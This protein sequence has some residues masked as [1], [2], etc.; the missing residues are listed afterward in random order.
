MAKKHAL[1]LIALLL[2]ATVARADD[3]FWDYYTPR[4]SNY[5][6]SK[7][8]WK[9]DAFTGDWWGVRNWLAED[10]G[11]EFS[12]NY[13]SNLAGNPVGGLRQ[14]FTYTDN[15]GFGVA[16]DLEKLAGWHGAKFTVSAL[17]RNGTSLSQEYIGN[18]FTVQQVYGGQR[19]MF[20]AVHLEQKFWDDK[21]QLKVGRFAT[22]DDFASSPVY[23]LYMNNGIDGNPQ[24]LPVNAQFSAY[25]WAVWATR[26]RLDPTP[27]WNAQLG[28][29][30]VSNR[31]FDQAY[32]GLNMSMQSSDGLMVLG[33][34]GWTPEFCKRPVPRAASAESG[35]T[36]IQPSKGRVTFGEEKNPAPS[37]QD[38]RGLPGHYWFGGYYSSW[39]YP[40]F[41]TS[42]TAVG[43]YGFYWHGDQMI[44]QE[45]PGSAQGFTLWTAFVLSPE[46]NTAKMPFQWNGGALYRGLL[47]TRDNDSL[48]FGLA[49]GNFSNDYGDAGLAYDGDAVSYEMALEWGYRVQVSD[50][51]YLQPDVQY[52][53]QPGGT[54][55]IPNALVLGAQIGVSF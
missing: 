13:T 8:W 33:Q 48:L 21:A 36:T 23:W 55:S 32:H 27:E 51:I 2:L 54:G 43:A 11:L 44:Y 20:Y 24:A 9:A 30:Q 12:L 52:I 4:P 7:L 10:T 5:I 15:I 39:E 3:R 35:K 28:V 17:D 49:Y 16:F 18:Q 38:M 26:L 50:F 45:S 14:G 47:P 29:Y 46:Q 6:G 41:G 1:R 37:D 22:G 31:T 25:P 19:L 34:I 53:I 42:S 40:Q